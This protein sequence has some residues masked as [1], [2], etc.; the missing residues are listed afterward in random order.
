MRVPQIV[1][2]AEVRWDG[3]LWQ[4]KAPYEDRMR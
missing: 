1:D 2:G 3:A 4:L